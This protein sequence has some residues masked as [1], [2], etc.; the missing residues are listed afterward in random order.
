MNKFAAAVKEKI[1][2]SA[3]AAGK[4]LDRLIRPIKAFFKRHIRFLTAL[5]VILCALL[6]LSTVFLAAVYMINTQRARISDSSSIPDDVLYE[7][8]YGSAAAGMDYDIAYALPEFVGFAFENEGGF[9]GC[10]S[11]DSSIEA[12]CSAITDPLCY[13]LG[14][15]GECTRSTGYNADALWLSS[16]SEKNF[17]YIRFSAD[18]PDYLVRAFFGGDYINDAA[19]GAIGRVRELMLIYYGGDG[20]G[21]YVRAVARSGGG[22]VYSYNYNGSGGRS[23]FASGSVASYYRNTS[24]TVC[25]FAKNY[26]GEYGGALTL[27]PSAIIFE[28]AQSSRTITAERGTISIDDSALDT[29]LRAFDYNPDKLN[30]YSEAGG[31]EVYIE[32]HGSLRVSESG[33]EYTA[34]EDGGVS[35]S[36]FI[37]AGS[38]EKYNIYETVLAVCA[39]VERL[40]GL[41]GI[42]GGDAEVK[43]CGAGYKNGLLELSFAYCFNGIPVYENSEPVKAFSF[44]VKNGS[45]VALSAYPLKITGLPERM[46]SLPQLWTLEKMDAGEISAAGYMR[47]IYE[48]ADGGERCSASWQFVAFTEETGQ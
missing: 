15:S 46:Q 27:S 48:I 40:D 31:G 4:T 6:A 34:S 22:D 35:L 13:A 7:L 12:F 33:I 2:G 20:E 17:I 18:L 39:G 14:S 25:S 42:R 41:C 10:A 43:I 37:G 30:S 26:S 11:G 1:G 36:S 23:S 9:M 8:R 28:T 5:N 38:Y 19:S 16:L 3:A 32:E 44:T 29:L 45:I 21:Y 24:F 47:Q